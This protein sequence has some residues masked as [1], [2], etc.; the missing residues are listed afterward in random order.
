MNLFTYSTLDAGIICLKSELKKQLNIT[1]REYNDL[2]DKLIN[3]LIYH[4]Q[5]R[6][7]EL[8][9]TLNIDI[10]K[11][12]NKLQY[13]NVNIVDHEIN[14]ENILFL[15]VE[16]TRAINEIK[17]I[18]NYSLKIFETE[19]KE[20]KE[21]INN[22][23]TD[24]TELHKEIENKLKYFYNY[25]ISHFGIFNYI[26]LWWLMCQYENEVLLEALIIITEKFNNEYN[27]RLN[28]WNI[29]LNKIH[30]LQQQVFQQYVDH[31]KKLNLY[32]S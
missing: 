19:L 25:Y 3:Y 30:V 28:R 24:N 4:C 17:K 29:Y 2:D 32:L 20:L 1:Y 15:C 11:L 12:T 21:Q 18:N 31:H 9:K 6:F 7:V 22:S 13:I 5:N 23:T 14:Y 26:K 16:K 27:M 8:L 10:Y